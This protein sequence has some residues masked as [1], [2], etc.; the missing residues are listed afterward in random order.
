MI[1]LDNEHLQSYGIVN[2]D[3]ACFDIVGVSVQMNFVDVE[4]LIRD[5]S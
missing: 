4:H 5:F 1:Y 3:S 2:D